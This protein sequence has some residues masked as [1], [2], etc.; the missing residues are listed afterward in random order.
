MTIAINR[1]GH[2]EYFKILL[3]DTFSQFQFVQLNLKL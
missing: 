1:N 3:C 2:I